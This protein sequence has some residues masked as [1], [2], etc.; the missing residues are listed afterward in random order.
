MKKLAINSQ[1]FLTYFID[2]TIMGFI[3]SFIASIV[4]TAINFDVGMKNIIYQEML[5]ELQVVLETGYVDN[6]V[7]YCMEFIKYSLVELVVI[8]AC[9]SI[10]FVGYLIVLPHYWSKQTVGR[11]LFKTKVV[12]L[13]DSNPTI[14]ARIIREFVGSFILYYCIGVIPFIISWILLNKHQRSLADMISGTKLIYLGINEEN[15]DEINEENINDYIDAKFADVEETN[16]VSK[17]PQ[18]DEDGYIV[19]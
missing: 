13:D 8:T 17:E 11:M 6:Y 18:P 14:K 7:N 5:E 3:T 1:R 15:N 16:N 4:Y 2:F 10:V 9:A 19:F 12:M